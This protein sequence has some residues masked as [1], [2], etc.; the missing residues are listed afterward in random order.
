MVLLL[1]NIIKYIET[2]KSLNEITKYNN[3]IYNN[4]KI[5]ITHNRYSTT[6]N[7]STESLINEIQ[8]Y[9]L[10][11][12]ILDFYLVHNGNISNIT[13]YISYDD[14]YSDTQNIIKF[15]KNVNH[16]ILKII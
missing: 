8:L 2:I 1:H 5:A 4:L 3:N 10:K 13:K 12:M 14:N 16:T 11:T 9:I 15:F 6:K 7:K